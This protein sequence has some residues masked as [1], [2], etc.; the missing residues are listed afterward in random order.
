MSPPKEP[1]VIESSN[2]PTTR[3]CPSTAIDESS[4]PADPLLSDPNY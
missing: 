3:D 4:I 2:Q 1:R